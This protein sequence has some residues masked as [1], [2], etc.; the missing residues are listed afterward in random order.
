MI[1]RSTIHNWK[2]IKILTNK[3]NLLNCFSN[4]WKKILFNTIQTWLHKIYWNFRVLS[5]YI[6]AVYVTSPFK[7][8]YD[9]ICHI[10]Y[11]SFHLS[12]SFLYCILVLTNEVNQSTVKFPK[13]ILFHDLVW[14][15]VFPLEARGILIFFHVRGKDPRKKESFIL[16]AVLIGAIA[17]TLDQA[18]PSEARLEKKENGI[19]RGSTSSKW[20]QHANEPRPRR[21]TKTSNESSDRELDLPKENGEI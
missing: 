15:S 17:R 18:E 1:Q 13:T 14:R 3:K 9:L 16:R 8:R 11:Y 2:L 4:Y 19:A 21:P 6:C 12:L 7:G 5:T 10:L 20:R